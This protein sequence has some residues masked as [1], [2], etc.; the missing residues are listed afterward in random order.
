M[1]PIK[2]NNFTDRGDRIVDRRRIAELIAEALRAELGGT[3]QAAKILMRW[4]N[5]SERTV[6]HWLAGRHCP[7]GGHLIVLMKESDLVLEA[8]LMAADRQDALLGSRVLHAYSVVTELLTF[9]EQGREGSSRRGAQQVRPTGVSRSP[10]ESD[11]D[12]D[13]EAHFGRLS[14]SPGGG[15]IDDRQAWYLAELASGRNVR[16]ADLQRR[17]GVSEKT[18][19]R[20]LAR[21]KVLGRVTYR[22]SPRRGKY[23]L[24]G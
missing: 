8:V 10:T 20:D 19:R 16:A 24:E 11:R 15:R 22:G 12:G 14:Q 17:W 1:V 3:H 2:G 4:T 21:L 18:A 23:F 13:R 6:K 9:V 5:A 7:D